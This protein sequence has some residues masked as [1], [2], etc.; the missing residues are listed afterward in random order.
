[1]TKITEK[2]KQIMAEAVTNNRKELDSALIKP[3]SEEY[4]FSTNGIYF[5]LGKWVLE[6]LIS[7]GSIYLLRSL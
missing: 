1:M 6:K 5:L 4:P 2:V 3:I 7:F